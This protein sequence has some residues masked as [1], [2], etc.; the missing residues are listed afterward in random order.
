[1]SCVLLNSRLRSIPINCCFFLLLT[2]SFF[3]TLIHHRA[4]GP[5]QPAVQTLPA[6]TNKRLSKATVTL[7]TFTTVSA[8]RAKQMEDRAKMQ[9]G[10]FQHLGKTAVLERKGH[11]PELWLLQLPTASSWCYHHHRIVWGRHGPREHRKGKQNKKIS[12]LLSYPSSGQTENTSG[13][14]CAPRLTFQVS[15]VLSSGKGRN[16][17]SSL[18]RWWSSPIPLV[19]SGL[20]HGAPCSHSYAQLKSHGGRCLLHLTWKLPDKYFSRTKEK[21]NILTFF[22]L[23]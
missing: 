9:W 15:N 2:W 4:P 23:S 12:T 13:T 20:S 18:I 8:S 5:A 19:V 14:V 7:N 11:L 3:F 16:W 6:L 21:W 22:T 1:M 10:C 17:D